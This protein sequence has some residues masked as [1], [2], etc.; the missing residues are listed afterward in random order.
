MR[1]ILPRRLWTI[2]YN[3]VQ[4]ARVGTRWLT[5]ATDSIGETNDDGRPSAEYV[6]TFCT[7]GS[8]DRGQAPL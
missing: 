8:A 3:D 1:R 2:G 4:T 6:R 5:V 7:D